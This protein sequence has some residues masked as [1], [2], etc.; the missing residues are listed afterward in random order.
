MFRTVVFAA[1]L[2]STGAAADDHWHTG[3]DF[4]QAKLTAFRMTMIQEGQTVGF[5]EYGWALKGDRYVI[6]DRTEMQPNIVETAE[7]VIDRD[8]LLPKSVAIDFAVGDNLMDVDLAWGDGWRKGHYISTRDGAS[9]T[10][11]VNVQEDEPAT[12]R[13]AVFGLVAAM[14]LDDGF[15]TTL[16][17]FNTLAN[18]VETVAVIVSGSETVT[19]PAGSFDAFKVELRGGSP[20]NIIY[21]SKS[22]PRQIV[23]IDVVGHAMHFEL[24]ATPV[25][26]LN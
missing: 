21:V 6:T 25:E 18:R 24:A 17:W 5:M 1:A 22:A 7:G 4:S 23:R 13:M 26:F 11:D 8:S 12:L 3:L 19:T 16:S 9:T 14:P 2:A 10:R 20:E 15:K